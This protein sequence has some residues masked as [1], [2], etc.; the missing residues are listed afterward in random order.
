[1]NVQVP[2]LVPTTV[3][4]YSV[5]STVGGGSVDSLVSSS[6]LLNNLLLLVGF[7]LQHRLVA[8]TAS[9]SAKYKYAHG[10]AAQVSY[11]VYIAMFTFC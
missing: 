6:P 2:Y 10:A 3:D 9:I 1:M 7:G 8:H 11:N 5:I 4:G